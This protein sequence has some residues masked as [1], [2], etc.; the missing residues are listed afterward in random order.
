MKESMLIVL[1]WGTA[2]ML[3]AVDMYPSLNRSKTKEFALQICGEQQ[4]VRSEKKGL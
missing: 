3:G 2:Y 1:I 4:M